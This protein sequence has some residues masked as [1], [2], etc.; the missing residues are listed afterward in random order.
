MSWMTAR[1]TLK[2]TENRTDKK[3][4]HVNGDTHRH[5]VVW[6]GVVFFLFPFL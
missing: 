4:Q 5:G 1:A 2:M 6:C 3:T